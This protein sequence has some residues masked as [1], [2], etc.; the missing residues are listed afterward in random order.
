VYRLGIDIGGTFTDY[1]LHDETTGTLAF[2]KRL[3]TS[4]D[5]LDG[6][7]DGIRGLLEQHRVDIG[8]VREIRH[9]T[10]LGSNVV[11][12]RKG[13]KTALITTQGFRDILEIQRGRRYNMFDLHIQRPTPLVPRQLVFEVRERM[14]H[15][16][17]VVTPVDVREI[18]DVTRRLRE[19]EVESVAVCFLHA[20]A[21]AAHE[22][23]VRDLLAGWLPNLPVT[24]SS[25]LSLQAREYERASTC[26]MNAYVRPVIGP[27]LRRLG[28]W[29]R[30]AGFRGDLFVMQCNGGLGTVDTVAQ[31]PVRMIES[32]PAAGAIAA[33]QYG[34]QVGATDVMALDMG[35]TTAK[36]C[37]IERGHPLMVQQLEIARMV[38]RRGS[39][40]P[41]DVPA[42]DLVEIGAGGGS[43][44][45][46]RLGT[47]QVGPDSAGAD[48]GPICYGR[49]GSQPTVT[50]ANLVLGYL[51]PRY[52]LGGRMALDRDR[53]VEG[54]Q[55]HVADPLGLDVTRAAWGIH[56]VVNA[57][58]VQALRM[59]S[60][61]RGRDPRLLTL[62]ATGGAG[63]THACRLAREL[64]VGTVLLPMGAGVASALGLLA[65]DMRF[66]LVRTDLR[67]IDGD[68][69]IE[70]IL[71]RL[72]E[73]RE[74]ALALAGGAARQGEAPRVDCVVSMRYVGQGF[75]VAVPTTLDQLMARGAAGLVDAF[76]Q[77]YEATYGE[78]VDE[79]VE[80]VHWKLSLVWASPDVTLSERGRRGAAA[81]GPT[82]PCAVFL[83]EANGYVTCPV[84]DREHL[85]PDGIIEGPAVV[86]DAESTAVILPGDQARVD[87]YGNITVKVR[88]D[89]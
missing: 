34:R 49:G 60:V 11:V 55:A 7:V 31:F 75:E 24:I 40:L 18:G 88:W 76:R 47:I 66:D 2:H 39:G 19:L 3:T 38:M 56:E 42:I 79:P 35:G 73:L 84:Y 70:P 12:E 10:T 21:N 37:F 5:V 86:E 6:L 4:A 32:G 51:N 69:P 17:E 46:P 58:M 50:D 80:A 28:A 48:P 57:N 30:A 64:G 16:G 89:V 67:R 26:V 44:A 43:I 20:Y 41:L 63:P 71:L 61:A 83:P 52:F 8:T 45:R 36:V 29:L 27:Y 59:M 82:R 25:D 13:P 33:V 78:L 65:A 87:A 85:P 62:V 53:A 14:T 9:G 72:S 68:V 15:T 54:I 1:V 74:R 22:R 23:Q 81:R 77:V